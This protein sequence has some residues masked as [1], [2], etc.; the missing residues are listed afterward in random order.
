MTKPGAFLAP[1]RFSKIP[2]SDGLEIR[3]GKLAA[4]AHHVVADLLALMQRAHAG[5]LDRGNLDE[6]VLC[7]VGRLD[8]TEAFLRVEELNG[9]LSHSG[10]PFENAPIGVNDC[11]AIAQRLVR[12]WRCLEK[13]ALA[14]RQQEQ[15]NHEQGAYSPERVNLQSF[16]RT[17][18]VTL[19]SDRII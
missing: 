5:A 8:E 9:T 2:R 6:H 3:S 15:A 14:G 16:P 1:G 19:G 18:M 7:A 11:A 17:R 4:L 13:R 12:V 10:P